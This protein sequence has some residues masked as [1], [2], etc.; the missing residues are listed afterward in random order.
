MP[1]SRHF[2]TLAVPWT[3]GIATVGLG[4]F[5]LFFTQFVNT[6]AANIGLAAGLL[7]LITGSGVMKIASARGRF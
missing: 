3:V 4:I 6:N 7:L 2:W 5:V 1:L